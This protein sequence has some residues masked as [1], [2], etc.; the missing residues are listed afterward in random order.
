MVRILTERRTF[1]ANIVGETS[2][3]DVIYYFTRQDRG[4]N[5]EFRFSAARI[6]LGKGVGYGYGVIEREDV[7]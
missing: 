2:L 4:T 3:P 7:V 5:T 6:S 1:I